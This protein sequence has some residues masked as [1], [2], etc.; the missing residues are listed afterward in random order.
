MGKPK[1]LAKK[2]KLN[3]QLRIIGGQ[4]RGRKIDFPAAESLRPTHDRVRETLF[5]WLMND[6]VEANCLDLYAGSGALGFE[7]LSRQ[8]KHV[9]M[10]DNNAEVTQYLAQNMQRLATKA[11]SVVQADALDFLKQKPALQYD[12]VFLD[13]PFD[14]NTYIQ[15]AKLLQENNYLADN[16]KIYLEL[17]KQ[18]PIDSLPSN[19]NCSRSKSTSTIDYYLFT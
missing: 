18:S 4:W 14:S 3:N 9:T 7:A 16:A 15:V 2:S 19:W 6:I 1:Q 11:C 17:P 8:A 12:I 13:P 10:V 5:N